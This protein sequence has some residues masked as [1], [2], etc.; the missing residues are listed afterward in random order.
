MRHRFVTLTPVKYIFSSIFFVC[1]LEAGIYNL[2]YLQVNVDIFLLI[3]FGSIIFFLILLPWT[4]KKIIE[5][6]EF[7]I[8]IY[9]MI[10]RGIRIK[11]KEIRLKDIVH[12]KASNNITI[13]TAHEEYKVICRG[14]KYVS[15]YDDKFSEK[16]NIKIN[17]KDFK[18][19]FLKN[20]VKFVDKIT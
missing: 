3:F 1:L 16:I 12:L 10:G 17:N 9:E 8:Y 5:F 13:V 11:E 20:N 18:S 14:L 19:I 6:D 7:N 2:G 15:V 4:W